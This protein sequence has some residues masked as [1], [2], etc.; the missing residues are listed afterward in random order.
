MSGPSTERVVQEYVTIKLTEITN[1]IIKVFK[2]TEKWPERDTG[3]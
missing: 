2:E 1:R 3:T